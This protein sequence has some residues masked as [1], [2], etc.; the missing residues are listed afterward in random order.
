MEIQGRILIIN[1]CVS[2]T[3]T[4]INPPEADKP[5]SKRSRAKA[6]RRE[7]FLENFSRSFRKIQ[8]VTV[9]VVQ[10]GAHAMQPAGSTSFLTPICLFAILTPNP[11]KPELTIDY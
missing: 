2:S 9:L 5:E 7:G 8:L 11:D 4:R 10:F 1:Y 3:P 6:Q